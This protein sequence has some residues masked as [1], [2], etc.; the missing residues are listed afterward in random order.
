MRAY[1]KCLGASSRKAAPWHIV[2][3]DDK[4]NARLI[5]SKIILDTLKGLKMQHPKTSK[6][7]RKELEAIRK[8]PAHRLVL[9][10]KRVLRLRGGGRRSGRQGS[11]AL[12]P[13][14]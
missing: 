10:G 2:P 3:A 1:E 13:G 11:G 4:E 12:F 7:H 5:I 8:Q 14:H 6:T 9:A